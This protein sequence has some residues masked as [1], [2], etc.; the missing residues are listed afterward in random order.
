MIFFILSERQYAVSYTYK[1]SIANSALSLTV[2]VIG[3]WSVFSWKM[4]VFTLF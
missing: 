4:H 3:L 2:S 1:W